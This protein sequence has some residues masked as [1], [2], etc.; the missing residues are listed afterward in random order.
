MG[1]YVLHTQFVYNLRS[2]NPYAKY[3]GLH[4]LF[5]RDILTRI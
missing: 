4:K 5:Y 2:R 1:K 3:Y